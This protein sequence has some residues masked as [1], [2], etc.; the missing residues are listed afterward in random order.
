MAPISELCKFCREYQNVA[1]F[2]IICL[3]QNLNCCKDKE[4]HKLQT[5]TH[6]KTPQISMCHFIYSAFLLLTFLVFEVLLFRIA[7]LDSMPLFRCC[8][9]RL[10]SSSRFLVVGDEACHLSHHSMLLLNFVACFSP[11]LLPFVGLPSN[12][13]LHFDA[14]L[15]PS[16][17]PFVG[18]PVRQSSFLTCILNPIRP[19]DI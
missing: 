16:L 10:C 19:A 1:N 9:H 18:P 2:S 5:A 11:P 3:R 13:M 14:G 15:F 8:I 17:L 4:R 6:F 12:I 7:A